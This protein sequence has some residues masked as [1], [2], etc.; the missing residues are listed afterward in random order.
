MNLTSGIGIKACTIYTVVSKIKD[1]VETKQVE[2]VN[3]KKSRSALVRMGP[4]VPIPHK[5]TSHMFTDNLK[6]RPSCWLLCF[7]LPVQNPPSQFLLRWPV[8]SF[9]VFAYFILSIT[10]HTFTTA[11]ILE[12]LINNVPCL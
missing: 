11:L 2:C 1:E 8:P 9:G 10:K 7:C 12:N 3:R 5:S 4:N 6:Q